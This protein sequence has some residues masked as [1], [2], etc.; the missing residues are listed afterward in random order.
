MSCASTFPQEVDEVELQNG[1]RYVEEMADQLLKGSNE[2]D[3]SPRIQLL[4]KAILSPEAKKIRK[5]LGKE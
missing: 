4:R 3:D 1:C 2:T 5:L